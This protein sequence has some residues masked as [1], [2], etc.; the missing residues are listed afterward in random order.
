M[1]VAIGSDPA[2][3]RLRSIPT[4]AQSGNGR[5]QGAEPRPESRIS[6]PRRQSLTLTFSTKQT[7]AELPFCASVA[8]LTSTR[9]TRTSADGSGAVF[10]QKHRHRRHEP[11]RARL[12]AEADHDRHT[13]RT[14]AGS[15]RQPL[16]SSAAISAIA[17][18][19]RYRMSPDG[20]RS[21]SG[22]A[23]LRGAAVGS[24]TRALVTRSQ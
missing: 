4:A 15:G 11:T 17:G 14:A 20:A 9:R 13:T 7:R 8:S 23:T 19:P 24:A 5:S 12:I 2:S 22:S 16:I 6:R 1:V 10:G 21:A 18:V 3:R